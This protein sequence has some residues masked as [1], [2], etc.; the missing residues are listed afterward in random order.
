MR[1]QEG[2]GGKAATLDKKLYESYFVFACLWGLGGALL[3]D[4]TK[5][6]RAEFS[7]WWRSEW[8]GVAFPDKG[9]VFDYYVNP[10]AGEMTPWADRVR[11]DAAGRVLAWKFATVMSLF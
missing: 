11:R 8:K 2:R 7:G 1:V 5:D 9:L 10:E 6:Y 4:K 3:V